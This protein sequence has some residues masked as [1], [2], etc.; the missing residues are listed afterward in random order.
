MSDDRETHSRPLRVAMMVGNDLT[1]DTRVRKMAVGLSNAGADVTLIGL[2]TS[3]ARTEALMAGVKVVRLPVPLMLKESAQQRRNALPSLR[4]GYSNKNALTV[5]KRRRKVR[6]R[7]IAAKVGRLSERLTRLD[8]S[9]APDQLE[10]RARQLALQVRRR[11]LRLPIKPRR[12]IEQ[13]RASVLDRRQTQRPKLV[14]LRDRAEALFEDLPVLSDWRRLIPYINDYELSFGPFLDEFEPDVIHAHDVHMVGIAERAVARAKNDGRHI[15]WIYDAHEYVPGLPN[16]DRRMIRG[17]VDLERE[18]AARSDRVITVSEQIAER[19]QQELDL[20]RRPTVVLNVPVVRPPLPADG[21][22][23]SVREAAG[24]EEGEPLLVYSGGVSAVRGLET[25]ID[26]LPYLPDVHAALV[27]KASSRVV[28]NLLQMAA[29]LGVRDRVHVVPFVDPDEVV[30]Y[31]STADVGVHT[32]FGG[33]L[34]HELALP[35]KYFE[36]MHA[37]LPM[38]GTDLEAMGALTRELGIGECFRS[39]DSVDLARAVRLVLEDRPLYTAP[40]IERPEILETYT[41]ARQ[42]AE[43]VRLYEELIGRPLREGGA[44]TTPAVTAALTEEGPSDDERERSLWIGPANMAGQGWAWKQAIQRALPTTRIE[45]VTLQKKSL[46]AFPADVRVPV[47]SWRSLEWQLSQVRDVLTQHTHVLMEAG[48]GVFGDLTGDDFESDATI[49]NKAG[50][51][52]GVVFHGSE[53]RDPRRHRELEP[54]SPYADAESELSVRLQDVADRNSELLRGFEGPRFVTTLDL[55]DYVPGAVWL[56]VVADPELWRPGDEVLSRQRPVVVHVPSSSGMKGSAPVDVIAE[57]LDGLGVIEYR[58]LKNVP[59]S[60]MPRLLAEADVVLDQFALGDYGVLAVQAALAGRLVIGHVATRVRE[61]LGV[62]LP[63]VEATAD[64]V[65]DVLLEVAE[66]RDRY[67]TVA[68]QGR[69]FAL[70]Y[71]SGDYAVRQLS[72]FWNHKVDE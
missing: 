36:Y 29:K 1:A 38:V 67:R 30:T 60:A 50:I 12:K 41:W 19:M 44:A 61:R 47:A 42:E 24:V 4:L 64:S 8:A 7:E 26:A 70:E 62:T 5:A 68:E 69:R 37:R 48:N 15:L 63:I 66:D 25:L 46:L 39:G 34:N 9:N 51:V 54:D 6:E 59:V 11:A 58:R 71:H 57:E 43:M 53:I 45:V 2:S 33:Y 28:R 52:A 22:A 17:F 18:Y 72:D 65:R 35:N 27:V 56:P 23:P 21:G 14:P 20:R 16:P 13:I 32:M 3:G 10:N 40:Y 31:L 49:L 55:L